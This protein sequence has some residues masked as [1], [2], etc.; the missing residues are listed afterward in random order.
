MECDICGY[1]IDH[2]NCSLICV[3]D[4]IADNL[5]KISDRLEELGDRH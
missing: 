4:R 5:S 3:L 1:T 2:C